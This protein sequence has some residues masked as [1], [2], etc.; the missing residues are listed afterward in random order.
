MQSLKRAFRF[1][2]ASFKL[3]FASP[4]LLKPGWVFV[5]G[6][7]TILLIGWIPTALVIG[8][9]GLTPFGLLLIGMM[10]ALT[11]AGL[12]SWG[13]ITRLK[14]CQTF[15]MKIQSNPDNKMPT[16][17][18]KNHWQDVLKLALALPGII[19]I[20]FFKTMF[21]KD[22]GP[23]WLEAHHLLIPLI[24]LEDRT[25]SNAKKR[26]E[27]ITHENLL[28]FRPSLVRTGLVAD[29]SLTLLTLLGVGLGFV[30]GVNIADPLTA[31]PWRQILASGAGML[32]AGL[33][34]LIG[35][36]INIILRTAY[37]TALYVWVSNVERAR[38]SEK[39]DQAGPP[40]I[41]RKVLSN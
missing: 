13:K 35:L 32:I 14:T 18:L 12:L 31:G 8:L 4:K 16:A 17:P 37:H 21:T 10:T 9:I 23:S 15:S 6:I 38:T 11:L 28:R 5:L 1:T 29:V 34:I 22:P 33:L 36:A 20:H 24:S 41:L 3:V 25:L 30:V 40:E 7:L 19:I 27:G 2:G 39:S 26:L